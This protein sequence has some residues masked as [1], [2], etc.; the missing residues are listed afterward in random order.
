MGGPDSIG[1]PAQARTA[2]AL[3]SSLITPPPQYGAVANGVGHWPSAGGG[4]SGWAAPQTWSS[5]GGL[6]GAG[7]SFP[8]SLVRG[9][10]SRPPACV[11]TPRAQPMRSVEPGNHGWTQ[12]TAPE[13]YCYYYNSHTGVSQWERPLELDCAWSGG[14][15]AAPCSLTLT[16]VPLTRRE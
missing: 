7:Q 11:L 14:A 3:S 15:C 12:H 6:V 8:S 1:G 16:A 2:Q 10:R 4:N 5:G 9:G 13:G